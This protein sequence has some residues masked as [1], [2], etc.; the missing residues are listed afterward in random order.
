MEKLQRAHHEQRRKKFYRSV[1]NNLEKR[2]FQRQSKLIAGFAQKYNLHKLV[3]C[4]QFD[5]AAS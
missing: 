2:I 5:E 4:E 3:Y 1:T